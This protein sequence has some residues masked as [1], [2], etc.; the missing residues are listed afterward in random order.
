MLF[1]SPALAHSL[2]TIWDEI[3]RELTDD[4]LSP[5]PR[6]R[7]VSAEVVRTLGRLLQETPAMQQY[8]NAAIER[9]LVDYI[10][11]WRVEIGNYIADVV[12]SWDGRQV[13]DL[14]ELQVGKDLQYIR[15]NGTIVGALIGSGLFLLGAALPGLLGAVAAIRF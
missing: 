8:L 3:K 4:A 9:L 10:A 6:L 1:R 14:I 11:P 15:I 5:S 7:V 13:A 12:A 2:G